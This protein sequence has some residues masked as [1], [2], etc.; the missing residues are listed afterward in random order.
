ME[1]LAEKNPL[2]GS[3]YTPKKS[4]PDAKC[5]LLHIDKVE[6]HLQPETITGFFS[7][8][9]SAAL[10][11]RNISLHPPSTSTSLSEVSFG[12]TD[13]PGWA[14]INAL[15][16]CFIWFGSL[17][18]DKYL[19]NAIKWAN[20]YPDRLTVIWYDSKL[21]NDSETKQMNEIN[22]PTNFRALMKRN[23]VDVKSEKIKALDIW[24]SDVLSDD[25]TREVLEWMY[26]DL[27]TMAD[28]DKTGLFCAASDFMRLML[29]YHG[30][31]IFN[32]IF[33]L[34]DIKDTTSPNGI[35]YFDC[36]QDFDIR[37]GLRECL[38]KGVIFSE[39]IMNDMYICSKS[40]NVF[41][42]ESLEL[43][44][45]NLDAK[46][47]AGALTVIQSELGAHEFRG[48]KIHRK[49]I[50]SLYPP[51]TPRYHS[52]TFSYIPFVGDCCQVSDT[53]WIDG[54]ALKMEHTLMT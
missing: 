4:S 53:S 51:K 37:K 18:P 16:L 1:G 29:M 49:V 8:L 9:F 35:I 54:R 20:A 12:C 11:K 47:E 22:N 21:I 31:S 48:M 45:E 32:G 2:Y 52:S 5:K 28:C 44:I 17:I 36:D 23:G 50:T 14:Y 24:G 46:K 6:V 41:F 3:G 39:I 42:K 26:L 30:K 43:F 25:I 33:K 19:L 10:V 27:S 38:V 40:H 7:D 34:E 15:P 13:R